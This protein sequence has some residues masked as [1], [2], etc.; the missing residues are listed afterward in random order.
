MSHPA[1]RPLGGLFLAL[2]ISHAVLGAEPA[3]R[4]TSNPYYVSGLTTLDKALALKPNSGKAKNL[5]LFIG[6]GMGIST[7]VAARI[8]EGQSRGVDG[9]SNSLSFEALP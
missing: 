3:A 6:D 7:L 9:V 8:H 2:T 4:Q 5:I 1:L